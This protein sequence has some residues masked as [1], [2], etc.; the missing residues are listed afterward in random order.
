MPSHL[1]LI[2]YSSVITLLM[3]TIR[4]SSVCS[5]AMS[6]LFEVMQCPAHERLAWSEL[7]II[8]QLAD[9]TAE[10]MYSYQKHSKNISQ[11]EFCGILELVSLHNA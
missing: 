9:A 2:P 3:N 8:M 6:H 5:D 7:L 4:G 10:I 11:E 1:L